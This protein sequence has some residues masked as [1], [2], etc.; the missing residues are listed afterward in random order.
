M[1][2]IDLIKQIMDCL[3][4]GTHYES[5][6]D[7]VGYCNFHVPAITDHRECPLLQNSSPPGNPNRWCCSRGEAKTYE[8]ELNYNLL[9]QDLKE[10]GVD[11][12]FLG[13]ESE[14]DPFKDY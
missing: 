4:S 7:G 11:A 8:L 12:K 1:D 13:D 3:S 10:F 6:N 14:D 2:E 9:V 5:T